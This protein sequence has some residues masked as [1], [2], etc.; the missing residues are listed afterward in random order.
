[1]L[2]FSQ[3]SVDA[4]Q[5]RWEHNTCVVVNVFRD[6]NTNNYNNWLSFG[7]VTWKIKRVTSFMVHSIVNCRCVESRS[8]PPGVR[9]PDFQKFL[10]KT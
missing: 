2:Q 4:V 9:G 7:G 6:K 1:M 10:G 5:T 3:S 8:P